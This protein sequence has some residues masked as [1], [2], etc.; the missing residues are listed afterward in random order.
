MGPES[1]LGVQASQIPLHTEK[2]SDRGKYSYMDGE[3]N[4][5]VVIR[6]TL[7]Q[8][9]IEVFFLPRTNID[10]IVALNVTRCD[11]VSLTMERRR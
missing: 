7:L 5:R 11:Y 10:L 6:V 4:F 2:I 3:V 1:I 9:I 8:K